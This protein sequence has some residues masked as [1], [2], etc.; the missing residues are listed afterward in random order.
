MNK[1]AYS[2][3]LF[4]SFRHGDQF[5]LF[6][7]NLNIERGLFVVCKDKLKWKDKRGTY[8]C[9]I[10]AFFSVFLVPQL[11]NAN[12]SVGKAGKLWQIHRCFP[13]I[14]RPSLECIQSYLAG[15]DYNLC[16]LLRYWLNLHHK[17]CCS[18]SSERCVHCPVG[19]SRDKGSLRS[20]TRTI[21]CHTVFTSDSI[22]MKNDNY[23]CCR[24]VFLSFKVK[25]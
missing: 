7:I 10:L 2:L 11:L 4:V 21:F 15:C 13:M 22:R 18:G 9:T 19:Y 23:L 6:W 14:L 12:V 16:C 1:Y 17:A 20:W 25:R 8:G 5:E 3:R 24:Q